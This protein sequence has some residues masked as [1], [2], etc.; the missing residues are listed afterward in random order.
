MEILTEWPRLFYT[1]L[2]HFFWLHVFW[3][4]INNLLHFQP[5]EPS[6]VFQGS[7]LAY[8]RLFQNYLPQKSR[9]EGKMKNWIFSIFKKKIFFLISP[10]INIYNGRKL[11]E[12]KDLKNIVCLFVSELICDFSSG[13]NISGTAGLKLN[14]LAKINNFA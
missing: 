3:W 13:V 9:F 2:V 5:Y 10:S 8:Q 4:N 1:F 6:Q 12:V 7:N 11:L 14:F